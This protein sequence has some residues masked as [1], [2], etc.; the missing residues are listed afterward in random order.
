MAGERAEFAAMWERLGAA[1]PAIGYAAIDQ[2]ASD[3]SAVERSAPK[4]AAIQAQA[5]IA[6]APQP[7]IDLFSSENPAVVRDASS[8]LRRMGAAA[9]PALRT[10]LEKNPPAD[11]RARLE[12]LLSAQSPPPGADVL[13]GIRAVQALERLGTPAAVNL[14]NA[15]A[16]GPAQS[17]VT[18][19]AQSAI[20]RVA[21]LR[22]N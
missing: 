14:L 11:V 9:H 21:G 12:L 16:A 2:L 19:E 10:A 13:R 7:L 22:H 18:Q 6:I 20:Q 3:P 4:L 1:S 5:A 15:L 17:P 8:R